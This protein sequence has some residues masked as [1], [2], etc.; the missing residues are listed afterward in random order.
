[1]HLKKEICE[2]LMNFKTPI[3]ICKI[4]LNM[5]NMKKVYLRNQ[6][7]ILFAE[8]LQDRHTDIEFVYLELFKDNCIILD[9]SVSIFLP[10]AEFLVIFV[11]VVSPNRT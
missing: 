4:A 7:K 9:A 3:L 10:M 8:E 2:N 6:Y 1:M 11:F 5:L